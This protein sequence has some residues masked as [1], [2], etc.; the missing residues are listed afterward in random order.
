MQS[1]AANNQRRSRILRLSVRV[2]LFLGLLVLALLGIDFEAVAASFGRHV[3][4]GVFAAQVPV[5]LMMLVGARRHA[6]LVANPPAPLSAAYGAMLLSAG[7]NQLIP[8]RVAELLKATYLRRKIGIRMSAGVGAVVLERFTDLI[9]IGVVGV[10][11][12]M[13]VLVEV[14]W[15]AIG[16][17]LVLGVAGF[18]AMTKA[19]P[20]LRRFTALIPWPAMVG[21]TNHMLVHIEERLDERLFYPALLLGCLMWALSLV[22]LWVYCRYSSPVAFS[23]TQMLTLFVALQFGAA[24]PV[25]PGGMGTVE[26]AAVVVLMQFGIGFDES[27]ALA[28]GL[29]LIN[30][31][32]LVPVA[33]ILAAADRTGIHDLL[34][35]LR[36]QFRKERMADE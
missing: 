11:A 7:F 32:V 23:P 27:V 3:W 36:T 9:I 5:L 29:R 33:L 31:V 8:G 2:A 24:I 26:A 12:S 28:I 20:L 25:L 1:M 10:V 30:L 14:D 34:A 17:M 19:M 6:I 18:F 22:S 35:D 21:F 4:V 13:L 16:L 15:Q